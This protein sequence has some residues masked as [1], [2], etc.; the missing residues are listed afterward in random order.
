[1]HI[2]RG[3]KKRKNASG[4]KPHKRIKSNNSAND[5]DIK[6]NTVSVSCDS[7][8]SNVATTTS[9]PSTTITTTALVTVGGSRTYAWQVNK[10]WCSIFNTFMVKIPTISHL[11]VVF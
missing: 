1:M 3:H 8:E 2:D 11:I 6:V 5:N 10:L 4:T 7:S 9:A